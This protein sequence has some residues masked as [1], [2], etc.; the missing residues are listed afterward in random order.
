MIEHYWK[1]SSRNFMTDEYDSFIID[2]QLK[3][4]LNENILYTYQLEDVIK[5]FKK[6]GIVKDINNQLL[7]FKILFN[8][9]AYDI[10][11]LINKIN[12]IC[13]L[14]GWMI[15]YIIYNNEIVYDFDKILNSNKAR[16]S[17]ICCFRPKNE[18][19]N[20]YAAT[21]KLTSEIYDQNFIYHITDRK[22]VK[23]ILKNGLLT[24]TKNKLGN[25]P[26]LNHF[27]THF[28]HKGTISKIIKNFNGEYSLKI[29]A[30]L[31]IDDPIIL[32]INS[33]YCKNY[34]I[35]FSYDPTGAKNCIIS[36][37][38]IPPNLIE[39]VDENEYEN[40]YNNQLEDTDFS[41]LR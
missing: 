40:I 27:L 9:D 23:K 2:N 19:K 31:Q 5:L 13:K 6:Y 20:N 1:Y 12:F 38:N 32:R 39:I 28:T 36:Y 25:Y 8:V 33:Q 24:R 35:K 7:T 26:E 34:N 30:K 10:N 41:L 14:T 15:S 11:F 21:N 4:Q 22:Y 29:D 18:I 3:N 37:N 16:L 17:F